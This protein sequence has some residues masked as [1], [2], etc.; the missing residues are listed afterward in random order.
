VENPKRNPHEPLVYA[1]S[2]RRNR[3][4]RCVAT[5]IQN[6]ACTIK[7]RQVRCKPRPLSRSYIS[8]SATGSRRV[9]GQRDVIARPPSVRAAASHNNRAAAALAGRNR[10][11]L[12]AARYC[13]ACT[14]RL[15][16]NLEVALSKH[17]RAHCTHA[18]NRLITVT[19]GIAGVLQV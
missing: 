4:V 18:H 14:V 9:K 1:L 6:G 19:A 12:L 17:M 10:T 13:A 15:S 3:S 16:V 8:D 7:H 5:C 2:T 11:A